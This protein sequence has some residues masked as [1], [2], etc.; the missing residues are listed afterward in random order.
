MSRLPSIPARDPRATEAQEAERLRAILAG[1]DW[2]PV[3]AVRVRRIG[4]GALGWLRDWGVYVDADP[5]VT[6]LAY[7]RVHSQEDQDDY[8]LPPAAY[9]TGAGLWLE[10]AG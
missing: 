5:R 8:G 2:R 4:D 3:G 1:Q 6:L 10:V 7:W 9:A